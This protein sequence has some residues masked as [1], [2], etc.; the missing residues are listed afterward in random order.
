MLNM[1]IFKNKTTEVKNEQAPIPDLNELMGKELGA[2]LKQYFEREMKSQNL[3]DLEDS[4]SINPLLEMPS[5]IR[6][7]IINKNI[8]E[9]KKNDIEVTPEMVDTWVKQ[10]GLENASELLDEEIQD[11]EILGPHE[12]AATK[13]EAMANQKAEDHGTVLK[14]LREKVFGTI[15]AK[16]FLAT[17]L[18]MIKFNPALSKTAE[19]VVPEKKISYETKKPINYD[20]DDGKG[21]KYD[22]SH[23]FYKTGTIKLEAGGHFDSNKV[24]LSNTSDLVSQFDHFLSSV[25][26]GNVDKFIEKAWTVYGSSDQSKR[27]GGNEPLTKAR[28]DA[29]TK[30]LKEVLVSHDF[31]KQLSAPEKI[32]KILT[33]NFSYDYPTDGEEKGVTY[34]VKADGTKYTNE[35]LAKLNPQE[36]DKVLADCS[37]TTFKA[38][39]INQ[40]EMVN[41][42]GF[43]EGSIYFDASKS[44]QA[45]KQIIINDLKIPRGDNANKHIKVVFFSNGINS[46]QEAA[47]NKDAIKIL[48]TTNIEGSDEEK[49]FSS[50]IQG[51]EKDAKSDVL[52]IKNGEKIP[53]RVAY[54]VTNEGLQDVN[55]I[56]K[57]VELAKKTNTTVVLYMFY[58]NGT[59]KIKID[60]NDL[61]N[62]LEIK[63]QGTIDSY[64]IKLA[65]V[66]ADKEHSV[67]VLATQIADKVSLKTLKE[68]LSQDKLGTK[69]EIIKALKEYDIKVPEFQKSLDSRIEDAKILELIRAQSDL[70]SVN[71]N[72][73]KATEKTADQYLAGTN[74]Q[75][76]IFIDK[77]GKKVVLPI[78]D[79]YKLSR[80]AQSSD[81]EKPTDI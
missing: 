27:S 31:S 23:D 35:D 67:D 22:A 58:N 48:R 17:V 26:D 41:F 81:V 80:T 69:A 54:L 61:K 49:V 14:Y 79:P 52:K 66:K 74:L 53:N 21:E 65:Q 73:K 2:T 8:E 37:Y 57:T 40:P 44:M 19:K 30:L 55:Q 62:T 71:N 75:M 6:L 60:L 42:D 72:L 46:I 25:N 76:K 16:A 15:W 36:R 51:M 77:N 3:E 7:E 11:P 70:A 24:D 56:L 18:F 20:G 64:K 28:I 39:L 78:T 13:I 47:N 63:A 9:C 5:D 10:I 32:N 50:L 34:A 1:N 59:E 68:I 12:N 29:F 38:E 33:K 4:E 45:P 43:D